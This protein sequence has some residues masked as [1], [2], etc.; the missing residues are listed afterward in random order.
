MKQL[1]ITIAA[2]MLVGCG[3]SVDI[4]KAAKEGNIEVVK[5]YIAAGAAV[6]AKRHDG[7]TPLHEAARPDNKE[8]VEL[9]IE[10][11]A[12]INAKKERDET[13]LDGAKKFKRRTQIEP[14]DFLRKHGGKHGTIH[15]AAY[16][17]DI[18][19]VKEFLAA[20]VDVNGMAV[21][22]QTPLHSAADGGH[23]EV[24]ELLIANGADVNAKDYDGK[25]PLE[26]A[27]DYPETAD[28]L[29]K[30]GGKTSEEL[31]AEGK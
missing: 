6:N 23:A 15:G 24:A 20:G 28:L 9:L 11:G 4:H 2:V 19:A 18:E 29:R 10:K 5:Q 14:A 31:K 1:L 30:H 17:G 3:P 13:P 25:T 8:I 21:N 16:G 27:E 7:T 22:N 26:A 12:D